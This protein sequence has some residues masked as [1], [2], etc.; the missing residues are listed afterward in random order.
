MNPSAALM[1]VRHKSRTS[2]EK[3]FKPLTENKK[4]ESPQRRVY[5]RAIGERNSLIRRAALIE[6]VVLSAAILSIANCAPNRSDRR[7]SK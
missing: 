3:V 2:T 6:G 4:Y 7:I 5:S 1:D